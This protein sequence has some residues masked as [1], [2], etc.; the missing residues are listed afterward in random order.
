MSA[1]RSSNTQPEVQL[2]RALHA[3]GFRYVLHRKDLPGRPDLTFPS[4]RKV[5]FVNGCFWHLHEC[6]Y[7]QVFPATRPEFWAQ[8]R[9]A[10]VARDAR[11]S[12]ELEELG[13]SVLT[14]W[15]CELRDLDRTVAN[16]IEF[17]ES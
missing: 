8:K 9:S 12:S 10:T 5:I 16:V 4:R 15:E 7:G 3:R 17:L 6:K 1:I 14:V 13:W 11:K 2:R